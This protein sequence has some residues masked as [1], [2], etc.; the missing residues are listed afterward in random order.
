MNGW[1][2]WITGLPGSGKTYR[3][4]ALIEKLRQRNI[5]VEYLRM[6]EIRKILTP[7]RKYTEE[8]R[9]HAYRA[10]ILIAKFLTDNGINV[11]MDATGHKKV[12]RELARELIPN[13]AEVY[14]K[15][16]LEICIER[17]SRRKDNLLVSNLYKKSM[18]RMKTG[19][20]V[21]AVGEMIG[22]D[23][24]YEEPEK[25]ELIINSDKL[26]IKESSDKIF[27]MIKEVFK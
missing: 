21:D 11:V 13:F 15:C 19:K 9:N 14:V 10:L 23:I 20:K 1:T 16:P 6:D 26:S 17:E 2:V 22:I 8:E 12:W 25:P 4:K 18:N 24:P 27:Q 7:E 5:K 3:A